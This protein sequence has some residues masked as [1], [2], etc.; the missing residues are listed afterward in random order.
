MLLLSLFW[1]EGTGSDTG[2]SDV[3]GAYSQAFGLRLSFE[4]EI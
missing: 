4:I 1:K 3:Y 2:T